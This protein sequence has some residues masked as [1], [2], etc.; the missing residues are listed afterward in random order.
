VHDTAVLQ[1]TPAAAS[2]MKAKEREKNPPEH[3]PLPTRAEQVQILKGQVG[4]RT[5][6]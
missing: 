5:Q 2:R 6:K 4:C 1:R 3:S